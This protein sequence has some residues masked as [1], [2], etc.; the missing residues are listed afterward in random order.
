MSAM[1]RSCRQRAHLAHE[2]GVEHAN[3]AL[4]LHRLEDHRR[5]RLRIQR[6]GEI[7][8]VALDDA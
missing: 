5:H 6:D 3:A 1:S 8:D 2:S 4:A 7:F